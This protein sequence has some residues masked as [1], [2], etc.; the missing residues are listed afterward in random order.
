[1]G[2]LRRTLVVAGLGAGW[3]IA[4]ALIVAHHWELDALEFGLAFGVLPPAVLI[5][6]VALRPTGRNIAS[7][8]VAGAIGLVAT[9]ANSAYMASTSCTKDA[10]CGTNVANAAVVMALAFGAAQ[11]ACWA[12]ARRRATTSH[13]KTP[14]A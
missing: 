9:V 1:M 8:A 14:R 6:Y 2:R 11:L 5:G 13:P 7:L 4:V 10:L 3:C 12:F